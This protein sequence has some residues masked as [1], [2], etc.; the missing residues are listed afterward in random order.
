[1]RKEEIVLNSD[2][3]R[4]ITLSF[5]DDVPTSKVEEVVAKAA[6]VSGILEV[7]GLPKV[8]ASRGAQISAT[9]DFDGLRSVEFTFGPGLIEEQ[10]KKRFQKIIA[11]MSGEAIEWEE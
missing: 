8:T 5:D 3:V 9:V 2:V 7:A 10:T 4:T 6:L 11:L 1:M